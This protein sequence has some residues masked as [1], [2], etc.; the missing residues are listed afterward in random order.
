MFQ[1]VQSSSSMLNSAVCTPQNSI[2]L[3]KANERI[4]IRSKHRSITSPKARFSTFFHQIYKGC[5]YISPK[6]IQSYTPLCNSSSIF[7]FLGFLGVWS[8]FY[9]CP[10]IIYNIL[11]KITRI[12]LP[13]L[14][15]FEQL[16]LNRDFF[17]ERVL[18][19]VK[20]V[21]WINRSV[22]PGL[23]WSESGPDKKPVETKLV[24]F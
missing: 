3:P 5:I 6:K 13:D 8:I 15:S 1:I 10:D 23:G 19:L 18:T 4:K 11:G 17:Q 12:T 7:A 14:Q 16:C 2:Q 21:K 24:E 20:L 22:E 9:L